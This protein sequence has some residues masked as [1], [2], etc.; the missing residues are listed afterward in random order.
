MC[1]W[2]AAE[3]HVGA[4][5]YRSSGL[6]ERFVLARLNLFLRTSIY[7]LRDEVSQ[8]GPL[9]RIGYKKYESM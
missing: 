1:G 6:S 9:Q 2:R 5:K 8:H 3:P 4:G 7:S